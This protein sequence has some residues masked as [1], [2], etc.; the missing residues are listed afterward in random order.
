MMSTLCSGLLAGWKRQQLT[1]CL[2][3]TLQTVDEQTDP[4]NPVFNKVALGIS[5]EMLCSLARDLT[6][7]ASARGYD[8]WCREPLRRPPGL[9]DRLLKRMMSARF[10]NS[11][12]VYPN[13]PVALLP[14]PTVR[15]AD[16]C[17]SRDETRLSA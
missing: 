10:Q 12:P 2:V 14:R 7:A 15:P 16:H 8:I 6:R 5:D 4:Q 1:H 9:V 3:V 13:A 11:T 17:L